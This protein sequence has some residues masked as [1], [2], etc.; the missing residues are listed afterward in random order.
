M[1]LRL[2]FFVLALAAATTASAEQT[3]SNPVPPLNGDFLMTPSPIL[4]PWANG[5]SAKVRGGWSERR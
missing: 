1:A 3:A 4:T 5:A 2:F